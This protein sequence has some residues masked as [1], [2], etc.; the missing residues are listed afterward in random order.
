MAARFE[1]ARTTAETFSS[2]GAELHTIGHVLGSDRVRG[3]SPGGHGND[4]IVAVSLLLRIAGQLVSAST[5]LFQDAG[6]TLRQP[7]CGNS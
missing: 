1:L 7:W 6:T 3:L 5:D 2:A 4:E